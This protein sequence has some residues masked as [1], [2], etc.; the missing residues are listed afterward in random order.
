MEKCILEC[1]KLSSKVIDRQ[2]DDETNRRLDTWQTVGL[3]REF[4]E[5]SIAGAKAG[6]AYGLAN[7]GNIEALKLINDFDWLEEKFGAGNS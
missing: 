1:C 2:K 6:T 5:Y 3:E 7:Q 4:G